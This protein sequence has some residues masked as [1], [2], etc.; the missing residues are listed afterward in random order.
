MNSTIR[1]TNQLSILIAAIATSLVIVTLPSMSRADTWE[2]R[3]VDEEVP[4]TREIEAGK[5]EKAIRISKVSLSRTRPALKVAVLTN[6]CI[7][8]ILIRDLDQAEQYCDLAAARSMER[9][10]THNNRGVLKALQGDY[11]AAVQDFSIAANVGCF[12][13]CNATGRAPQNL[14]RPVARRNLEKAQTIVA[15]SRDAT[16]A[17]RVAARTEQ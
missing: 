8:H 10:V 7:G 16:D 9:T 11:V 2:L 4:G 6:L 14:P 1:I 17:D 12:N 15:K 3:T 13:G 5:P